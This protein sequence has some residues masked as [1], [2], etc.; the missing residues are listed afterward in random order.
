MKFILFLKDN[1][2][3]AK[4]IRKSLDDVDLG[5]YDSYEEVTEQ[6]Y[7]TIELPA[8]KK[9]S[10]WVKTDV[11]PVI[12]YDSISEKHEEPISETE[13]VRAD[14]DYLAVMMGVEL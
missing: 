1:I 4:S 3:V 12:E 10:S 13:Q 5:V 7:N 9:D 11:F 8:Q 2:A 6:E 14:V